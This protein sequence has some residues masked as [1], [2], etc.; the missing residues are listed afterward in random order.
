MEDEKEVDPYLA[1]RISITK[2]MDQAYLLEVGGLCPLCGKNLL[3]VKGKVNSKLYQIAHIYPNSPTVYQ[4]KELK[5]LERLGNTCEDSENKI[6]L[7]KDCHGVYD[8]GVKKEEY[9]QLVDIKKKL[10]SVANSKALLSFQ[11]LEEEISLVLNSLREISSEDIAELAL[12]YKGLEVKKKFEARYVL[13]KNKILTYNCTYYYFIKETF[14]NLERENQINFN[15]VASEIRTSFLQCEQETDD[16]GDIFNSLVL[17]MHSKIKHSSLE[18]CEVVIAFF[19]QNCEVFDE[20]T[21]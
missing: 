5:G 12:K 11:Y 8:D 2:N 13:L 18:A 20:V 10:L 17:W 19:V 15:L 14:Q 7:C 16:K 4:I 9:L 6:A 21:E 3:T 1:P